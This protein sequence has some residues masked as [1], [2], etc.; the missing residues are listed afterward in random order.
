MPDEKDHKKTILSLN[1]NAIKT[2]RSIVQIPIQ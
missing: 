2:N 1:F